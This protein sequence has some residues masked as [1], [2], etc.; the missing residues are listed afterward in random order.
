MNQ[1]D[2]FNE[3]VTDP[4]FETLLE[5]LHR[6]R[7]FD[8]TGYKRASLLRRVNRRMA[9]V[10][11]TEYVNYMDF[12]E[13]HP[14]EF[15]QLFDTVLINVTGF[16]RDPEAWESLR[17]E[18]IPRLLE[19]KGESEPIR[20]WAA[21]CASGEEVYTVT[22]LL[23]EAMGV[24]AFRDRVK[25][26]GT[27]ADEAALT[28]ARHTAYSPEEIEAVPA[29]WRDRYFEPSNGRFGF[30][31]ELRRSLI[32]GRHDLVQDAPI[33]RIDLLCCRNTLMYFN[34]ETQAR[35][36]DRFHFALNPGGFLFLGKAETLLTHSRI[37]APVDLKR[38]IFIKQG[39][40]HLRDRLL[41]PLKRTDEIAEDRPGNNKDRLRD[42]A[43]DAASMAQ[44]VVDAHGLL[45]LANEKARELH[46]LST[47]DL[48]RPFQDHKVSY[49]PADL[50]SGIDRAYQERQS[51]ILKDVEW[52][53]PSNSQAL[54]TLE[55]H[56]APFLDP[57][58]KPLGASITFI[59]MTDSRR[60]K[61]ELQRTN[62]D[63]EAAYE[64]LQSTNEELETTNEEL[65]STV[66]ELETTNEELQSTNEELE[67]MNEELQSTNEELE[68]VNEE[69]RLRS[70]ELNQVNGYLRSILTCL[71]YGVIVLDRDLLIQ[72]WSPHAEDLWGLRS[73]EV[74]GKNLLALDIGLPID[75]LSQP[76][77]N[78][79]A[80][81]IPAN[82]IFSHARNRR[83]KPIECRVTFSPMVD[84][85][86]I[87]GVILMMEDQE[88]PKMI[89]N[90][91]EPYGPV[92][93]DSNG[94]MEIS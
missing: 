68:A 60:L 69:L 94:N 18:V 90:R 45:T 57:D 54:L 17:N 25:V 26:Y 51:I 50:R 30:H 53:G 93:K 79:L 39:R 63:L 56:I 44:V 42:A 66:E 40:G 74:L 77:H 48:G 14:N 28:R 76:I 35:I 4:E 12:L 3:T 55:I 2:P 92:Q 85:E 23:A 65:Q 87:K 10:N 73:G 88:G 13:V 78:C 47:V 49:R 29:E 37:F 11:I 67:T 81:G 89:E 59:D 43:F 15:G 24:E 52:R 75:A 64:E 22:I 27:D 84:T 8:F 41:Y 7:D 80:T 61:N 5:Y 36:I 19:R 6:V 9:T 46:G 71:P 34:Q 31:K 38:R 21:G 62:E 91:T 86:E 70:E 58:G 83:G 1:Q 32:F 16:F 20:V 72:L 33:S 82:I